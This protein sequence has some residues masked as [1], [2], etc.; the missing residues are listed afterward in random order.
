[1]LVAW[2]WILGQA[3]VAIGGTDTGV[4]IVTL[5]TDTIT[6][7]GGA[8][9]LLVSVGLGLMIVKMVV[10][11]SMSY[12]DPGPAPEDCDDACI[13]CG[14]WISGKTALEREGCCPSCDDGERVPY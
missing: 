1:M 7:F 10:R 13:M 12:F 8:M 14:T 2:A 6:A 5:M 11:K 3:N 9:L 4:D